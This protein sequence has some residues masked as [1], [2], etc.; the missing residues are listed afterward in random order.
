MA[1]IALK[2]IFQNVS[3]NVSFVSL[4]GNFNLPDLDCQSNILPIFAK[5][6]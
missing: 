6:A 2:L 3:S 5:N 1:S 4:R